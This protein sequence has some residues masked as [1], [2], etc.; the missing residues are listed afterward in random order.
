METN[1]KLSFST[2]LIF[3]AFFCTNGVIAADIVTTDL[4]FNDLGNGVSKAVSTYYFVDHNETTRY[5]YNYN[6]SGCDLLFFNTTIRCGKCLGHY[7]LSSSEG[8]YYEDIYFDNFEMDISFNISEPSGWWGLAVKLDAHIDYEN[9]TLTAFAVEKEEITNTTF[10]SGTIDSSEFTTIMTFTTNG[11]D[12][13]AI[14]IL[15]VTII[16]L[17]KKK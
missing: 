16:F 4:V 5:S 10:T 14:L 11:F 1:K 17:R 7:T 8:L 3:L 9:I 15:P 2:L 6:F 12:I 13:L